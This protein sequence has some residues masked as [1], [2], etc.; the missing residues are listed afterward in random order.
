[1]LRTLLY[2][3]ITVAVL[4]FLRMVIGIILKEFGRLMEPESTAAQGTVNPKTAPAGG[5]LKKDP[6]CG[7]FV[8]A[9]TS[10]KKTVS[11]DVVHF[12]SLTCRDKYL[13]KAKV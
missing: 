5:E 12:C 6:V 10:I 1:M 8:P 4:A 11:G 3:L 2:L 13:E 9:A 7:T